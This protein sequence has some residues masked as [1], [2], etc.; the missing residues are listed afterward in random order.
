VSEEENGL[1]GA[2]A[3]IAN[4]EIAFFGIGAAEEDIG[5]GKA[6]SAQ[7]DGGGFGNGS[8]G[9]SGKA[10]LDFDEFF[11]DIVGKLLFGFGP[12]GLRADGSA[13]D[14]QGKQ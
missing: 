9:A 6:G 8:C 1:E 13:R 14:K 5:F 11:I 2:G 10:G 12:R 4:D 7:A 3:V